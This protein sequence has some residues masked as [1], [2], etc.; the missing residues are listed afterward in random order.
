MIDR[1]GDRGKEGSNR[2]S[3]ACILSLLLAYCRPV[4]RGRYDT[5]IACTSVW[6][7]WQQQALADGDEHEQTRHTCC[8]RRAATAKYATVL[9]S[10]GCSSSC[11]C[12][13]VGVGRRRRSMIHPSIR[14]SLSSS[15]PDLSLH[16]IPTC[17]AFE[18]ISPWTFA[19]RIYAGKWHNSVVAPIHR[20]AIDRISCMPSP[21][22]TD[23][24]GSSNHHRHSMQLA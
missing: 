14:P 22:I 21:V 7:G 18:A 16:P 20:Q 15:A 24:G 8:V 12:D 9:A 17:F 23:P 4:Q 5:A 13:P 10:C 1:D 6:D 2:W 3:H 11:V 19:E